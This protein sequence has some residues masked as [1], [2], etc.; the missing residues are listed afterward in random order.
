M[1]PISTPCPIVPSKQAAGK[2]RAATPEDPNE[3]EYKPSPK[4]NKP[5]ESSSSYTPINASRGTRGVAVARGVAVSK[6]SVS[7]TQQRTAASDRAATVIVIDDPP[8][9]HQAVASAN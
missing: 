6:P 7:K 3:L 2:K 1:S 4:R 8:E 9:E 5:A